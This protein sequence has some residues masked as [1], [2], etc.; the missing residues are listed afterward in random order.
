[1]T[2]GFAII[3]G[4]PGGPYPATQA[5]R[6][7][8]FEHELVVFWIVVAKSQGDLSDSLSRIPGH[9]QVLLSCLSGSISP[10]GT[11]ITI[12]CPVGLP[13]IAR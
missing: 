8:N 10:P 9:L 1:M 3:A 4:D 2:P 7:A 5:F 12:E 11:I 13:I 6:S